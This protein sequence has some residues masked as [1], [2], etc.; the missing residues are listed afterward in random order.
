MIAAIKDKAD[1]AAQGECHRGEYFH[2]RG[3]RRKG[4][5]IAE[6]HGENREQNHGE[7]PVMAAANG[8]GRA[9]RLRCFMV[10]ADKFRMIQAHM[11]FLPQE[12]CVRELLRKN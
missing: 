6:K 11:S 5:D 2:V 3:E 7:Q 12:Q 9:L 10:A 1:E 8:P 4:E